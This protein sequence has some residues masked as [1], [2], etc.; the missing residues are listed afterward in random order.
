[1]NADRQDTERL[2]E[3][4]RVLELANARLRTQSVTTSD[5]QDP[6]ISTAA[7][8][9]EVLTVLFEKYETTRG[10]SCDAYCDTPQWHAMAEAQ[11]LEAVVIAHSTGLLSAS[12]AKQRANASVVRLQDGALHRNEGAFAQWGLGFRWQSFPAN[13]PFLVTTALVTRALIAAQGLADC[14]NMTREGL[15][16]LTRL[17]HD[18]IMIDSRPIALPV[19][20][21]TLPEV[22][23]N[24]V[25]LWAQVIK[26]SNPLSDIDTEVVCDASLALDWLNGRFVPGLGW[27][28]STKRPVFDLMHQVYILEGL[29]AHPSA[30]DIEERAIEV[31][32]SFRTSQGYIDSMTLTNRAMAIDK[33]ER[34]G[35]QYPVFRG[36]RV[37]SARI[38]AARLWSLGGLLVSFAL[39]AMEGV[40]RS[41]WLS[42]I[43]RFPMHMLPARFGADF[44]QEMHLARGAALALKALRATDISGS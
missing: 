22:V 43:R 29:H 3:Q 40:R 15:A 39:F 7:R 30:T 35:G 41:Y 24:T 19:Y 12:Q 8:L 42:Q 13:E 23:E 28:Y 32:A 44:R 14:L 9:R 20:A 6:T 37:L 17:P 25:A 21:P 31:F 27:A 33:A 10:I 38:D 36:D 1:M 18:E 16:G 4:I 26:A 2:K 11:Y 34:S 5:S